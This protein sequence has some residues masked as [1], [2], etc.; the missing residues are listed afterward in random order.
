MKNKR[1]KVVKAASS[2]LSIAE[3]TV[4]TSDDGPLTKRQVVALRRDAK[5]RLPKGK[6]ITAEVLFFS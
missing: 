5:N 2:N 6:T 3:S 1:K 4:Y